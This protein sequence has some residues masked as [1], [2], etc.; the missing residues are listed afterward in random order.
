MMSRRTAMSISFFPNRNNLIK[1]VDQWIV[2]NK[3][4]MLM[5]LCN[6]CLYKVFDMSHACRS[7]RV[8]RGIQRIAKQMEKDMRQ[9]VEGEELLGVC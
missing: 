3:V 8:K 2:L 9:P 4:D 5:S 1:E 7:C 6:C